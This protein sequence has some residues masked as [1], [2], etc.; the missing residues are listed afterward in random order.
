MD[1]HRDFLYIMEYAPQ[2]PART[3]V[4]YLLPAGEWLIKSTNEDGETLEKAVDAP[5]ALKATTVIKSSLV[6]ERRWRNAGKGCRCAEGFEGDNC[7][8]IVSCKN[9]ELANGRCICAEGWKGELCERKCI[10]NQTCA[11]TKT[12]VAAGTLLLLIFSLLLR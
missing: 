3:T 5:K 12:V 4:S 8:K 10:P 11:G 6:H 9:G 7:D 2:I 1:V